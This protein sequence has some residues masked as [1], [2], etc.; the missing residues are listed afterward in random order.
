MFFSPNSFSLSN[1]PTQLAY[2]LFN[3]KEN[4]SA[5]AGQ[6]QGTLPLLARVLSVLSSASVGFPLKEA[7]PVF[8]RMEFTDFVDTSVRK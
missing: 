2:V 4:H 3:E 1:H 6:S 7:A 5:V 8:S